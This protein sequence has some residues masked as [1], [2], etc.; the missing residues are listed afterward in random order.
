TRVC[1]TSMDLA[2][3]ADEKKFFALKVELARHNPPAIYSGTGAAVTADSGDDELVKLLDRTMGF[4]FM[5]QRFI[6]DSYMLGKLVS[7]T[8]G[9]PTRD[10]M[11]TWVMTPG[12]P[13]RGFPRGLDVMAVLGSKRARTLLTELGDDAYTGDGKKVLSYDQ[14]LAKLQKEYADLSDADWN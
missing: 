3:L 7:P 14:A 13:I 4:R 8:I 10:G 1:G 2:T 11:F 12:G 6:P 9:L 5:G